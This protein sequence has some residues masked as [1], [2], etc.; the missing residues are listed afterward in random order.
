MIPDRTVMSPPTEEVLSLELPC[1][2]GAPGLVRGALEELD[3][4]GWVLGDVLLISTELINCAVLKCGASSEKALR[5]AGG[6]PEGG[7]QHGGEHAPRG[8]TAERP[9][10]RRSHGRRPGLGRGLGADD[11]RAVG[12]SLGRGG[13][14]G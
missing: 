1:D 2:F 5:V 3:W 6:L 12:G 13:G 8:T 11:H 10:P 9:P 4:L 7:M 14:S